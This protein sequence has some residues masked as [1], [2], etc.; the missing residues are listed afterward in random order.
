MKTMTQPTL[1]STLEQLEHDYPGETVGVTATANTIGS[2][3]CTW[4]GTD[5]DERVFGFGDTLETALSVLTFKMA[6]RP[7][8]E[9]KRQ[10]K[11]AEL[12]REL[13]GLRGE[14]EEGK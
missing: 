6:S 13:A 7:S 1:E 12:E 9:T 10:Q 3:F 11:I 8:P 4:V 2:R 14:V 5:P